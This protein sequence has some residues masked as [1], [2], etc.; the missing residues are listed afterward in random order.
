LH[1]DEPAASVVD[2]FTIR[3][4]QADHGG[5]I[6]CIGS[7]PTIANSR[8]VNNRAGFGGGVGVEFSSVRVVNC[9]I[10]GNTGYMHG[11]GVYI[12]EGS[13]T[14]VNCTI[15][16]N[17]SL[18]TGGG[19]YCD[20]SSSATVTNSILWS[21]AAARGHEIDVSFSSV[22]TISH[23]DVQGGRGQANVGE[24]CTLDWGIGNIDSDP[25]F[26]VPGRWKDKGTPDVAGDDLW[27]PGDCRLHPT[28][29]CIDAGENEDWMWDSVDL[30]GNPRIFNDYVDLGAYECEFSV[31]GVLKTPD[32]LVELT[33]RSSPGATYTV[34]SC[35]DLLEGEWIKEATISP[36]GQLAMWTDS[37]TTSMQKFYRIGIE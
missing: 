33:W 35:S 27:I 11:G 22:L 23:S 28:S 17:A 13:P 2:G 5:G 37:D 30:D 36:Q 24:D 12:Y 21:N 6:Y 18:F 14:F 29:P 9:E 10:S 4:G 19:L 31:G 34:W 1:S 8:I 16:G 25:R 7:S 15:A 3:N 26:A 32:E 20:E